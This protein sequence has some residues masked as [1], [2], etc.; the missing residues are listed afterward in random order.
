MMALAG[1]AVCTVLGGCRAV[2]FLIHIGPI[3]PQP[4]P[5]P[6]ESHELHQKELQYIGD[7]E[8]REYL[9]GVVLFCKRILL[10]GGPPCP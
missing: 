8:F 7:S 10:F 9:I 4:P 6:Q 5:P 2:G 3:P 1:L